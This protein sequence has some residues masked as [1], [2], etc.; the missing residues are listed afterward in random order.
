M[1]ETFSEYVTPEMIQNAKKMGLSVNEFITF[2]SV[3]QAEAFSKESMG[4]VSSVFWNRLNSKAYPRLQ[5]DP[6]T[7]YAKSLSELSHYSK[8]MRDASQH[9]HR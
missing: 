9:F 6:T 1:L 5:S 2:G 3:V 4:G 8:D 7:K